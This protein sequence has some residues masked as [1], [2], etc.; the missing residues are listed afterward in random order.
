MNAY[1]RTDDEYFEINQHRY[2]F[3]NAIRTYHIINMHSL[4]ILII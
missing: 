4:F 2:I 1:S 3:K